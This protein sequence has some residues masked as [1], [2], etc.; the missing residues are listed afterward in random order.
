MRWNL[1]NSEDV[2]DVGAMLTLA[3][4]VGFGL[5]AVMLYMFTNEHLPQ[6]AVLKAT[7]ASSRLIAIMIL[8]Q[9]GSCALIGTG[10]GV[11]A[12]GIAS[13]FVA[14]HGFPFRMM[15]FTPVLG[16]LAV[17]LVSVSAAL[18][19]ALPALRLEPTAAFAG[20]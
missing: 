13:P 17:L 18:L 7:G 2:G 15:W 6:Y 10:L 20:R 9:A 11:G 14:A 5:T 4:T 12:C 1:V 19:S 16:A 3:V 8:V